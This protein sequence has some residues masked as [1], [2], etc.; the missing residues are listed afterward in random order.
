MLLIWLFGFFVG[1]AHIRTEYKT[2]VKTEVKWMPG[3]TIYQTIEH[4]VPVR[5]V[6]TI[7]KEIDL[8]Q[9]LDTMALY[10]VWRD[11]FKSRDYELHFGN[12]TI[13]DFDVKATIQENQLLRADA[14]I[15]PKIKTI[16]K[17]ETVYVKQ[18]KKVQIYTLIGTSHN[19]RTN[20]VQA[21]VGIKDRYLV[22]VSGIR[23]DNKVYYTINIGVKF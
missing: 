17:T 16:E 3:D 14:E 23:N 15:H 8:T 18:T 11:Y 13:G 1:R 9:P 5:V 20:Q 2:I 10:A 7:V 4:P 12:D 22:G 6:D 19:F 21:G